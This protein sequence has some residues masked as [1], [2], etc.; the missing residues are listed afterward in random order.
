MRSIICVVGCIAALVSTPLGVRTAIAAGPQA[1]A[2]PSDSTLDT[3]IATRIHKDASLKKDDIKWDVSNGVVTLTGTVAN[4]A[5]RSRAGAL[6][7]VKGV[8]RVENQLVVSNQ[9]QGTKGTLERKYDQGVEKTKDAA[10]KA[11]EKT[12]EGLGKAADATKEGAS[13][14]ID[15]T[16][17]GVKKVGS[18]LT[19]AWILG[20]V[21]THFIGEDAL[22][23]SDI[24]VDVDKHVVTLRG[25]VPTSAGRARAIELAKMT[26]GVDRVVDMLTIA[27]KK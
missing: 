8:T 16:K 3:R 25:T 21:K 23:G 13:A 15:K 6:A 10:S 5:Q 24:N 1:S 12:K 2:K 26:D 18:E 20:A 9:A 17:A 27:P 7:H 4:N 14:A 19:D 11:G 22:K